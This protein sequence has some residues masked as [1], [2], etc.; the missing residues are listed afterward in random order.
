MELVGW[1]QE[2]TEPLGLAEDTAVVRGGVTQHRT[3]RTQK[4]SDNEQKARQR[5]LNVGRHLYD[6]DASM[7]ACAEL[8]SE[9]MGGEVTERAQEEL[10]RRST[11]RTQKRQKT[12]ADVNRSRSAGVVIH[13]NYHSLHYNSHRLN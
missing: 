2:T 7:R 13:T 1:G 9:D 6:M 12:G 10:S 4:P 5:A 11:A 8:Q 3:L